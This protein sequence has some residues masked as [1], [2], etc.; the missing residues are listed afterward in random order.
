[1]IGDEIVGYTTAT[2][3]SINGI[4]RGANP[5]EYPVGTVYKYE[6]SGI[7]LRRLNKTHDFAD[8]TIADPIN[9]DSYNIKVDMSA[10]GID[11]T[12]ASGSSKLFT[13]AT[14]STGGNQVRA[15]R[16]FLMRF[17]LHR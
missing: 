7:S 14:K 4:T 1:M 12:A 11:R 2:G 3:G 8:V 15:H 9:F 13:T 6:T 16:T 10:D 17:L 5:A